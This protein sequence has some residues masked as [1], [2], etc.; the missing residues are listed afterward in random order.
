MIGISILCEILRVS[1]GRAENSFDTRSGR[2]CENLA[3][4]M[5]VEQSA[6]Y[7][8]DRGKSCDVEPAGHATRRADAVGRQSKRESLQ[9]AR[10]RKMSRGTQFMNSQEP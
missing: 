6:V 9:G 3:N 4:V 2:V 1:N 7:W 10:I 5:L 8:T